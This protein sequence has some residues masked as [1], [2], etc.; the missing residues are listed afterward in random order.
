MVHDG[1]W[2]AVRLKW[3]DKEKSSAGRLGEFSDAVAVMFPVKSRDWAPAIFMGSKDDPTH[4]FHWRAQYQRDKE[5][6]KPTMKELYPN[7]NPDMY[8]FEPKDLAAMPT[9]P[10]E[11]SESYQYGVAAGNPQSY[12]KNGVDEIIAEGYGTSAVME[13]RESNSNA[14]WANG[15]WTVVISRA[16]S[17]AK[18]SV[19]VPGAGSF[20]AFAVWQ[21]GMD[22]VGGRKCL[23]MVWLPVTLVE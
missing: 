5:S 6:G 10:K 23:T 13:E 7:M 2:L 9:T 22:E 19:L 3:A 16:L 15:E 8:P 21:G 1:K 18:G 14:V 20:A 11:V 4:I 12:I 17:R